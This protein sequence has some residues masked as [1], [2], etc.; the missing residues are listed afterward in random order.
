MIKEKLGFE[1][2]SRY[3]FD[4]EIFDNL[5]LVIFYNIETIK[6]IL[7]LL[8]EPSTCVIIILELYKNY[9]GILLELNSNKF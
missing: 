5:L 8:S 3:L 2:F 4:F 7:H 1:H 6:K 9:I